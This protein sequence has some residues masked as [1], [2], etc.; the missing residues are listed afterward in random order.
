MANVVTGA[1][2]G[3]LRLRVSQ[4]E[5]HYTGGILSNA[6]LARMMTDCGSE[7][8]VLRDGTDGYL[9]AYEDMEFF[10]VAGAGDFIEIESTLVAEGTR[11]RRASV[12]ARRV[13]RATGGISDPLPAEVCDPPELLARGTVVSVVPREL[14]RDVDVSPRRTPGRHPGGLGGFLRLRVHNLETH[15]LGGLLAGASLTRMMVD[16]A[17]EIGVRRDGRL[18]NITKF[19]KVDILSPVYAGDTLEISARIA[20]TSDGAASI[21]VEALRP[22]RI[23]EQPGGLSGGQAL[24]PPE[25]VGRAT[26]IEALLP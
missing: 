26:F 25:A 6:A 14:L 11:S 23:A 22:L 13:V 8:G 12:E 19:R 20:D 5:T 21:A 18:S 3:F 9:A 10:G 1:P 15:Y 16:C 24:D 17:S 2:Q 7:I 4:L